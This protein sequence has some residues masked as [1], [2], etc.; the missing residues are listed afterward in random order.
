M[1]RGGFEEA[2][3]LLDRSDLA[4]RCEG[5]ARLAELDDPRATETL[6]A[7]LS[8]SSWYLRDRVVEVLA[9]RPGA[10]APLIE[11]LRRGTWFARASAS[12]ALGRQGDPAAI[13]DLIRQVE[14]RNVSL[15]KSAVEALGRLAESLG[16]KEVA[17][18]IAK[19][20]ATRRRQ[21]V[22]RIGHQAPHRV[23]PIERA[24]AE[25]PPDAYR[26][27]EPSPDTPPAKVSGPDEEAEAAALG[28]FR[29]WLASLPTPQEGD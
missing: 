26:E 21:V 23:K 1:K 17:S 2:R 29:R 7:L 11:V 19:L 13:P 4:E 6:V 28:R 27:A 14:D 8:E 20:P 10:V 18:G 22:T 3:G 24:L 16:P 5:V 15:Q 12:E 25:L 9:G